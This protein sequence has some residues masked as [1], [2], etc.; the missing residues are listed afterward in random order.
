M[1]N[2]LGKNT[3]VGC[4]CLLQFKRQRLAIYSVSAVLPFWRANRRLIVNSSTRVHLYLASRSANSR[5][6][7]SIQCEADFFLPNEMQIVGQIL[8][9]NLEPIYLLPFCVIK[10]SGN[11]Q[12]S[13]QAVLL[14]AQTLQGRKFGSLHQVKNHD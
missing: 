12:H 3:G 8:T 10:I 11:L 5:L 7:V 6:V 14:M 4:Y 2:F 13:I 1:Y 9:S